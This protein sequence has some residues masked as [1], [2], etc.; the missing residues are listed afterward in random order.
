MRKEIIIMLSLAA[1]AISASQA[2]AKEKKTTTNTI[3]FTKHYDKSSPVLRTKIQGP[4]QPQT[5]TGLRQTGQ[6]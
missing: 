6:K 2:D 3:V 4:N 5:P 1:A